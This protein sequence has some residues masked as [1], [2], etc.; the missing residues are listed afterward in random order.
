MDQ[1]PFTPPPQYPPPQKPRDEANVGLNIVSVVQ[2]WL[3]CP[4]PILG[5]IL[6]FSWKDSKPIAAKSMLKVSLIAFA[7]IFV[8]YI[9]LFALGIFAGVLEALDS[10]SGYDPYYDY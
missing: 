9:G 3:C 10:S 5:I 8:I 6:Y 2:M 4:L 7:I 1:T